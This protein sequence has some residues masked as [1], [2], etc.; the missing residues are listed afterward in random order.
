MNISYFSAKNVNRSQKDISFYCN[1]IYIKL[2]TVGGTEMQI[3]YMD[4]ILQSFFFCLFPLQEKS[5]SFI[6]ELSSSKE[7]NCSLTRMVGL[8]GSPSLPPNPE[9]HRVSLKCPILTEYKDQSG[10]KVQNSLCSPPTYYTC[11]NCLTMEPM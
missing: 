2:L 4:F 1:S 9:H 10:S 7:T 8:S 5:S 6:S 3:C 11:K